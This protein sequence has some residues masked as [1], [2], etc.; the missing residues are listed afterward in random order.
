MGEEVSHYMYFNNLDKSHCVSKTI[1]K[2][3][4]DTIV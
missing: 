4:N 1:I 3:I 2:I